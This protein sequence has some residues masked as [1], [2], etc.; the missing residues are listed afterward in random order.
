MFL[1]QMKVYRDSGRHCPINKIC[2]PPSFLLSQK[3]L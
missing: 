3:E 2:A 1:T